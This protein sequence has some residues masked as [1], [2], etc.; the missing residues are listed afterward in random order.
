MSQQ[1][2]LQGNITTALGRAASLE[3][4]TTLRQAW[5]N[6]GSRWLGLLAGLTVLDLVLG[7][8]VWVRWLALLSLLAYPAWAAW[9][10]RRRIVERAVSEE[11]A[12]RL[13]EEGN[14]G[15]D[16]AF[17]NAVQ[18]QKGLEGAPDFRA[19]L[20]RREISRA[21]GALA[22]T[23]V[24]EA[25]SRQG[26]HRA[27]S[28]LIASFGAWVAAC[29]LLPGM[30]FAVLPRIFAPWMDDI[31]P[32]FSFTKIDI[33]P[34][35][36]TVRYGGSLTV[37]V[38]VKGPVPEGLSLATRVRSKDWT[39]V[40]LESTEPREYALT[41]SD[42]REDTWIV[43]KGG[44]ARSGRYLIRVA[45][46]PVADAVQATYVSPEYTHRPVLTEAV[47]EK[48]IHGFRNTK[49]T[50]RVNSNRDLAGGDLIIET[51]KGQTH[52]PLQVDEK[53]SKAAIVTFPITAAGTFRI[54][55]AS[56]D[57][58]ENPNAAQGKIALERDQ[59]PNV[60]F[61]EPP[62]EIVVTPDMKVA[63]RVLADDDIGVTR[64][65]LHRVINDISDSGLTLYEGA[66]ITRTGATLTLDLADL[67]VRPGD[68]I[69]YYANAFDNDPGHP[70]F[71]RTDSYS[72]HVVS[73]DEFEH[74]LKQQRNSEELAREVSNIKEAID[75]LAERQQELADK[76][77]KLQK[78]LAQKPGDPSLA[79]Q[80]AEAQKQ[81]KS[82]QQE[83]RQM[84]ERL[85][86]YS[87][88]PSASDIEK[89]LKEKVAQ[90]AAGISQAAN[91]AMQNAQSSSLSAAAQ[92]AS[93]AAEALKKVAGDS[94]K[95]VGESIKNIEKVAPLF[96]DVERFKALFNRQTQ[97]VIQAK[98]FEQSSTQDAAA[99][100]KMQNIAAEQERVQDELKAL[101]EDFRAHAAEAQKDFP[102]AA[103]SALKIANEIGERHIPDLMGDAKGAFDKERGPEG[104]S[105]AQKAL[106]QMQAMF[107]KGGACQGNC[108][109]E[110]DIKLQQSL[111]KSG[112]G[113]SLS[114]CLNPGNGVG[115]GS[116]V[117]SGSGGMQS[118]GAGMA[119]GTSA[120]NGPVAYTTDLKSLAGASG[121][122]QS[123]ST[124]G[125]AGSEAALAP[126]RIENLTKTGDE[127][128]RAA[129]SANKAYPAEYRQLIKDY[130]ISVTKEKK[131]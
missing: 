51:D 124:N 27:K 25:V 21:E 116:G 118:G 63:L 34:R 59:N 18:F 111:G 4:H 105:A 19:D 39:S 13:L 92:S 128:P 75:S 22:S 85:K 109:G 112:L 29:V 7:V 64:I 98:E 99:Q 14:E 65:D 119:G 71:A 81:Q 110:L 24:E 32:P 82:L 36:A 49:V 97:L 42:L 101:Q 46:P 53:N 125:F 91:G 35:G 2:T 43:A 3:R 104:F 1:A 88:S 120:N 95:S 80:L 50:L 114:A 60:W 66:P 11:H 68:E 23:S 12:A 6:L 84:A 87:K 108:K 33:A 100:S 15:L 52:L 130:F 74:L 76:M 69:T 123:H 44:N 28:I 47:G 40:P 62:Q 10:I 16:N 72:I 122:K 127:P 37:K 107:G 31:T 17:I 126:D 70:N 90:A 131:K 26:E 45:L 8:A 5:F 96:Q 103:A 67:G 113:Q 30:V 57:A 117:G 41:L 115:F 58:Q 38:A 79:K 129:D 106:D 102:K 93:Q 61:E 48:G 73:R 89:A 56:D 77:A 9:Q 86:E 121:V 78:A 55:L 20:M 54:A 94:A 83:A